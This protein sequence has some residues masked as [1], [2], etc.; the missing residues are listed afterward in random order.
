MVNL[1]LYCFRE[2]RLQELRESSYFGSMTE[3]SRNDF[4]AEVTETSKKHPVL[5]FL[6][7]TANINCQVLARWLTQQ[8]APTYPS[9]KFVQIQ[10][11][12][13]IQNYPDANLPT[14]LLYRLGTVQKQL[15]QADV[16]K[17]RELIEQILEAEQEQDKQDESS[18]DY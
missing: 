8:A 6:Y 12:R 11:T 13:C 9:I 4:V 1:L 2:K 5:V 3:I 17:A 16:S 18:K 10:S 14:I 15:L 7:Q